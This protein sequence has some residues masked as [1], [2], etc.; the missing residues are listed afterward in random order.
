MSELASINVT[1]RVEAIKKLLRNHPGVL[2][3]LLDPSG[4]TLNVSSTP[5]SM[6]LFEPEE[7]LVRV[8]WDIWNGAGETEFHKVL[9]VLEM[10]DF[11]AFMD[12]M[13]GFRALRRRIHQMYASGSEND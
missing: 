4:Q 6:D 11:N 10:E 13:E 1:L 8:A 9:H 12:A 5:E 2:K 7:I 3:K